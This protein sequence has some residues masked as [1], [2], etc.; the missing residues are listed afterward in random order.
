[1]KLQ[2]KV[3]LLVFIWKISFKEKNTKFYFNIFSN[4]LFFIKFSFIFLFVKLLSYKNSVINLSNFL[5]S[6]G[7]FQDNL[8]QCKSN[9]LKLI[10]PQKK[11][12]LFTSYSKFWGRKKPDIVGHKI[13]NYFSIHQFSYHLLAF[14]F[15]IFSSIHL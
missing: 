4:L 14:V 9:S 8:F 13:I 1:M 6:T 5:I 2:K 11:Q 12:K 3:W 7:I 15:Q 10:P